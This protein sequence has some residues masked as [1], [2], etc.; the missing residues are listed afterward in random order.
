[1]ADPPLN[2]PLLVGESRELLDEASLR[3]AYLSALLKVVLDI[4]E[5][6]PDRTD[7][8]PKRAAIEYCI[9]RAA[10][11][12]DIVHLAMEQLKEVKSAVHSCENHLLM[13]L[14]STRP[15]APQTH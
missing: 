15:A 7:A 11:G 4:F 8:L 12:V 10:L 14:K 1:M 5:D 3:G 9:E 6:V 2:I 13:A